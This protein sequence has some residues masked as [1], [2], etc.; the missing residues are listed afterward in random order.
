[1]I[2]F[3]TCPECGGNDITV[4]ELKK[5]TIVELGDG[6]QAMVKEDSVF[7][8]CNDCAELEEE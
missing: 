2:K 4:H 1:M 6:Q 3:D 7:I 8:E 5:G